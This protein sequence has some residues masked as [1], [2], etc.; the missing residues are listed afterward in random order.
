MDGAIVTCRSIWAILGVEVNSRN[1][2]DPSSL[3]LDPC[4]SP[5][6]SG[7]QVKRF[8]FRER[9]SLNKSSIGREIVK[10]LV[11]G[12]KCVAHLDKDAD[13]EVDKDILDRV[14]DRTVTEIKARILGV[15][16]VAFVRPPN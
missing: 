9:Y 10:V 14:I 11:A 1:K 16:Q 3:P 5:L 2:P 8:D 6:P 7:V 12:N 13:H 4:R 15:P